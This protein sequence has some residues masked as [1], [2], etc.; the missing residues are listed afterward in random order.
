MNQ[1]LLYEE[2]HFTDII[3]DDQPTK[4]YPNTTLMNPVAVFSKQD[5]DVN[6]AVV[7]VSCK[8]L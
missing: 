2:K 3:G 5:D 6:L 7:D 4:C 8:K 1:L